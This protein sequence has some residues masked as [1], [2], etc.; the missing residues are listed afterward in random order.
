[1][2]L[3]SPD[4]LDAQA[5]VAQ[6]RECYGRVVYATKTHEK[7]ADLCTRRLGHLKIWQIIL[8]AVTTSGLLAAL[9]GGDKVSYPATLVAALI[10][11]L[12]LALNAYAKD[13]DPGQQAEKHKKTASQLWDVRESYLSLLADLHDQRLTSEKAS[14]KRDELQAR[15]VAIYGSAPRT[16]P[17]AYADA[18]RGLKEQEE[19]TFSDAEIDAFLPPSLRSR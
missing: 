18:S 9:F 6:I 5:L 3:N 16:N 10:S 7:C 8:S 1:M 2:A 11:L 19:L 4:D 13:I 14:A 17:K 15:L 12:L